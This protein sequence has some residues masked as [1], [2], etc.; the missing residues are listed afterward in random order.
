MQMNTNLMEM[1]QNNNAAINEMNASTLAIPGGIWMCRNCSKMN[2]PAIIR[3]KKA[4]FME[5]WLKN[6]VIISEWW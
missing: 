1:E 2:H 6:K 5:I 4:C 3:C